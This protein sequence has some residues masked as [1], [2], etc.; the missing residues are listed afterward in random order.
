[1]KTQI[2]SIGSGQV[3]HLADGHLTVN[4]IKAWANSL[5]Y[6]ATGFEHLP[7]ATSLYASTFVLDVAPGWPEYTYGV[8]YLD[9]P[10]HA[11]L[12][13][14][15]DVLPGFTLNHEEYNYKGSRYVCTKVQNSAWIVFRVGVA[16]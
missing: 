7:F 3:V 6:V 14:Y 16:E 9:A 5:G 4:E 12:E 15:G 2:I 1:M 8:R 10:L 13:K 11:D